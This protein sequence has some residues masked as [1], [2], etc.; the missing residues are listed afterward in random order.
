MHGE[1]VKLGNQAVVVHFEILYRVTSGNRGK[2]GK[3][4]VE[5]VAQMTVGAFLNTITEPGGL[6]LHVGQ[7]C[8]CVAYEHKN[9]SCVC[10]CAIETSTE[11]AGFYEN[12]ISI[13]LIVVLLYPV[14]LA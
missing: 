3:S 1:K 6:W 10:L 14:A 5:A 7:M 2:P 12:W 13:G 8:I 11:C 4:S 9:I